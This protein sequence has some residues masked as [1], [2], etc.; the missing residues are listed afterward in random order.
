MIDSVLLS[1]DAVRQWHKLV[2]AVSESG[3][4]SGCKPE[5]IPDEDARILNNG[6]LEIFVKLP[7]NKEITMI[8]PKEEWSWIHS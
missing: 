8:V 4:L 1:T 7:N 6:D 5:E 3:A 2:K